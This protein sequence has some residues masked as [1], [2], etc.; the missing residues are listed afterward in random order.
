MLLTSQSAATPAL[1]SGFIAILAV[2]LRRLVVV[3]VAVVVVAKD[4]LIQPSAVKPDASQGG[5]YYVC[6]M[7]AMFAIVQR[8]M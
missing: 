5:A 2:E 1:L 4:L 7:I 6:W 8:S 3:A